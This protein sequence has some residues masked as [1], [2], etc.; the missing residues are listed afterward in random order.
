[1]SHAYPSVIEHVPF[2]AD[3]ILMAIDGHDEAWS[4]WQVAPE[5]N[6]LSARAA[7]DQTLA[8][9]LATPYATRFGA[10]A[11]LRHLR[12]HI[13][14]DEI[15][16]AAVLARASDAALYLNVDFRPAGPPRGRVAPVLRALSRAGELVAYLALIAGGAVLTGLATL[17]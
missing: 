12:W 2:H 17:L 9:L 8:R 11:L 1:M 7:M 14:H 5:T 6:L 13:E 16:D 10:V 15:T 4:M 3:P